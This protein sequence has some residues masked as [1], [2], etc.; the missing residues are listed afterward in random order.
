MHAHVT[1]AIWRWLVLW[2]FYLLLA[3]EL[4]PTE[5]MFGLAAALIATVA[6]GIAHR[7]S[8]AH[9]IAMKDCLRPLTVLPGKTI[10]DCVIVLSSVLNRRS[11]RF[12]SVRFD[13]GNHSSK[14]ATRR[15]LVVAGASLAPNSFVVQLDFKKRSLLLHEFVPRREQPHDMKW[16]L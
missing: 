16:P 11:G 6:V 12:T 3:G 2:G 9:F 1:G 15:A 7:H 8:P 14:S 5:L 13:P 4:N 10:S